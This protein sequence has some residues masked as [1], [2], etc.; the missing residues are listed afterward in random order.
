MSKAFFAGTVALALLGAAPASAQTSTTTTTTTTRTTETFTPAQETT[1]RKYVVER[2]VKPVM[3]K[4]R[5]VVGGPVPADIELEPLPSEV[6]TEVPA[7]RSYRYFASDAGIVVVNPETRR[8][9][10]VIEAQ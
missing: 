8:V 9:V 10:R 6:V 3:V 7:V 2:K 1:I 5:I 4:E